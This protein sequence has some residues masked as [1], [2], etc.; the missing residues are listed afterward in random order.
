[1]PYLTV[2]IPAYNDAE[3]L[4]SLVDEAIETAQQITS[5]YEIFV[6][7]DGSKDNTKDVALELAGK[8]SQVKVHIHPVNLGFGPTIRECYTTPQSEWI[9]FAPGDAQIPPRE[10]LK[11]MPYKDDFDFII[12]YRR[13]RRDPFYRKIQSRFYNRL[14]TRL[15]G[16]KVHDVNSS[17]LVRRSLLEG[18]TLECKSAFIHAKLLL[19]ALRKGARFKEVLIEHRER[20]FG[21]ASGARP[22]VILGTVRDLA[23]YWLR[24][25]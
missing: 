7:D 17:A 25:K 22:S 9:F 3:T 16:R 12:G 19:E 11:L 6:I 4:P 8:Y 23:G 10:L 24:K 1:M 2:S 20:E 14:I 18:T 15:A 13:L 5:D 21:A